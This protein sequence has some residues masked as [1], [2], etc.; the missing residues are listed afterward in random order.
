LSPDE[1]NSSDNPDAL[2]VRAPSAAGWTWVWWRAGT[3]GFS[4]INARVG[5]WIAHAKHADT[6]HL[7]HAIFQGGRFD[8][9]QS[10]WSLDSPLSPRRPRRFSEQQ[11]TEPPQGQPQQDVVGQSDFP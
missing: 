8:P 9:C 1:K 4:D 11:S 10:P 3:I 6:W 7:R 2:K 5:A